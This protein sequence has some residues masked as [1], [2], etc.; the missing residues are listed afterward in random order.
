M[1][2]P[3]NGTAWLQKVLPD[4]PPLPVRVTFSHPHLGLLTVL[5]AGAHR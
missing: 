4:A 5:L 2:Q 3:Q 1:H